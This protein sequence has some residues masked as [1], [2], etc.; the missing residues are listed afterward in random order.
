MEIIATPNATSTERPYPKLMIGKKEG[1]IVLFTTPTKGTVIQTGNRWHYPLG[2]HDTKWA[3][4]EFED[5]C[6]IIT[7]N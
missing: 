3:P 1:T 6:G 7:I 2:Y 4:E 5:Y